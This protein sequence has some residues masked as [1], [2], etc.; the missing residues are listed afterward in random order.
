MSEFWKRIQSDFY[1][2]MLIDNAEWPMR[3]I[4]FFGWR[5]DGRVYRRYRDVPPV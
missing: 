2:L 3:A 5:H 1:C 4:W